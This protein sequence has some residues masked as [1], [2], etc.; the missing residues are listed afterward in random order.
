M[1][2]TGAIPRSGVKYSV[3]PHAI[4]RSGTLIRSGS[5]MVAAT[6]TP[7]RGK[8]AWVAKNPALAWAVA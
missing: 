4:L 8:F 6:T 2:V 7:A 5:S 3:Q 1:T